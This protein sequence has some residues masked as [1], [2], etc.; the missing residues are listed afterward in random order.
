MLPSLL[1]G[2]GEAA[3]GCQGQEGGWH[4]M[5]T[6]G[7]WVSVG[8]MVLRLLVLVGHVTLVPLGAVVCSTLQHT[9]SAFEC[10]SIP[11]LLVLLANGL[12]KIE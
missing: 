6:K 1:A 9:T 8:E 3:R 11:V 4:R 2:G 10:L 5:E 12:A 7:E